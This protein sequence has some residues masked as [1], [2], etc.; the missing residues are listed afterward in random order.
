MTAH[1]CDEHVPAATSGLPPEDAL[2][3]AGAGLPAE[4]AD[5]GPG[6]DGPH[7]REQ[8]CPAPRA[9]A[10]GQGANLSFETGVNAHW[11]PVCSWG[12][13]RECGRKDQETLWTP[14]DAA[15]VYGVGCAEYI[16]RAWPEFPQVK[17]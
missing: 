9:G 14:G 8:P 16:Y 15:S 5:P 2:A 3:A 11:A 12:D 13:A 17:S 10:A 6:P 7:L 4:D 1:G